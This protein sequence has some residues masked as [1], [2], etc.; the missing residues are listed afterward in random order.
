MPPRKKLAPHNRKSCL[1]G[2][3]AQG[4]KIAHPEAPPITSRFGKM[5][6]H[7]YKEHMPGREAM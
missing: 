1:I 5:R 7:A 4:I 6:M 3:K 2:T